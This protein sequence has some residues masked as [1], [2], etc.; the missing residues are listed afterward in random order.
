MQ[1]PSPL[2]QALLIRRYKRFLAD[3]E[4]PD[5]QVITVHCP[6]TGS[7]LRCAEPGSRVWL[8][9]SH[10]PKR[11]Y[12]HSWEWVEVDQ[13]HLACINTQRANQLVAE[14]LQEDRIAELRGYQQ[15]EKEPKVED[16]RLDFLLHANGEASAYVE[17]KNVT[18]LPE[19]T[20][21]GQFPDAVTERGRKHL[22]RLQQLCNEGHRAVLLFCVAHQGINTVTVADDIDSA[23]GAALR[24]VMAAGVEV[25]AYQVAFD[26]QVPGMSLQQRLP[27]VV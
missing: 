2:Q 11:K 9:D 5:R 7:M 10:N 25:L 1:Y 16:G 22:L 19:H 8:L 13:Q 12:R 24:E 18:L 26:Q 4:L 21:V 17:V 27:L 14:A 6:N 3:V 15:V 23:Y 20:S